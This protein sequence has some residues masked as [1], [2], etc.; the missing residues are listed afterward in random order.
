L[1]FFFLSAQA[2]GP[3][4]RNATACFS[5]VPRLAVLVLSD[6]IAYENQKVAYANAE[7]F[8]RCLTVLGLQRKQKIM[9]SS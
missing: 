4:I 1:T 9:E 6:D 7:I 8:L 2:A 3:R 5:V